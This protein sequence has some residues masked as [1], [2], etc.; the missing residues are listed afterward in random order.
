MEKRFGQIEILG[1]TYKLNYSLR[2]AQ[3]FNDIVSRQET[4][5]FANEEKNLEILALMMRD[6]AEFER[7]IFGKD[8]EVLELDQLQLIMTPADNGKVLAAIK[9]TVELGGMQFVKAK[10][11]KNEGES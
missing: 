7:R 1:K 3:Q 8:T 2:I 4:G 10:S 9:E 5:S 6:A 11:K